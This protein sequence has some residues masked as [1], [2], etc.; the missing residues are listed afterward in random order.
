[1]EEFRKLASIQRI[2]SI[3][4]ID[5]ADKIEV[6]R[7]NNWDVVVQKEIGYKVGDLVVYFEIDSYLPEKPEF[8]FLRKS[9]FKKMGELT[10]FRL[11]TIK[12]RGVVSQGLVTPIS[13]L[14]DDVEIVEGNDV[15][16][17]L[18]VMKY[19]PPIP[20]QL[21]GK[22]RGNF[23]SW[24]IKSDQ[25]RIQNLT[26]EF[27]KWYDDDVQWE[28]TIKLDGTS[29]TA[30]ISPNMEFVVC[31]RNL[32]LEL[33][34]EGNTLITVS[35]EYEIERKLKQ[36]DISF[37]PYAV[38]GELMGP[39]VHGNREKLQKPE[40]FVY[41]VIDTHKREFVGQEERLAVVESLGLKHVPV[42]YKSVTFRE[43]GLKT[44]D[45]V[46]KFAD[47]PSLNHPTREGLV[48]K[49]IN[50]KFSFKVISNK[51]LLK[52]KS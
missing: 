5:G 10:G 36:L 16:E 52:D 35:N 13:V 9:S 40:L 25:G 49:E 44:I 2:R 45:D 38:Q 42:L 3:R 27:P 7:I 39:G 11:K 34:Q 12:L 37:N 24:L 6:V 23:P 19:D 8:E 26:N 30:G 15:T 50:G 32:S 43:L 14:P 29:M 31:S 48:F 33:E 28:I 18:G 41:N 1:M 47:G 21:A 46:I 51:F 22:V 4:P 17:I 20:A